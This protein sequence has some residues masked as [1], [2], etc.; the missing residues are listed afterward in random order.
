MQEGLSLD[1]FIGMVDLIINFSPSKR[2]DG[3]CKRVVFNGTAI[4]WCMISATSWLPFYWRLLESG[5]PSWLH[6]Y[7]QL[8]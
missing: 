3:L 4:N 5:V 2:S 8:S 1:S 6:A 7:Y